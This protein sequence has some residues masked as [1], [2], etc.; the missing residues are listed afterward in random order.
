MRISD[1]AI[2]SPDYPLQGTDLAGD[3][4][5]PMTP[6][7]ED[8]PDGG[9]LLIDSSSQT[10]CRVSRRTRWSSVCRA[11]LHRPYVESAAEPDD[12][13]Y[14]D[15]DHCR[16]ALHRS[17]V[18]SAAKQDEPDT[19]D[20]APNRAALHRSVVEAAE[21]GDDLNAGDAALYR[22]ALQRIV[23][24]AAEA[25]DD[26]DA[27]DTAHYRQFFTNL[28]WVQQRKQLRMQ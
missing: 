25:G 21:V 16:A 27:G 3:P 1:A 22:A 11:A 24:E 20:T 28:L 10:C 4:A 9:D 23:I 7:A 26:P 12:H 18:E 14:E 13:E 19:G 15:T 2:F 8:D 6:G 5:R 17:D